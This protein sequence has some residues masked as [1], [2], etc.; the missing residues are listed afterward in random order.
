MEQTLNNKIYLIV[1]EINVV[2]GV[3]LVIFVIL[4][5][6]SPQIIQAYVNLNAWFI[7]WVISAI[8]L[9]V[10]NKYQSPN[11]GDSQ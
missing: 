2:L 5:L 10:L 4:E 6:I 1:R 3:A 9:L 7:F 11:L 8:I